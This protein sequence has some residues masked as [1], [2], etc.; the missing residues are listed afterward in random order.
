L[1]CRR[2]TLRRW[3]ALD[4][5]LSA[6]RD[7][8]RALGWE[9]GDGTELQAALAS[10]DG[11]AV[12]RRRPSLIEQADAARDARQWE[13]AA[14]CY[15]AVLDRDPGNAAIW[16][17]YGHALKEA[18]NLKDPARLAA[19]EAAYRSALTLKP[20]IADAYLQFGHVLKLQGRAEEAEAAYL[21]AFALDPVASAP[22]D[23]LRGLG[24]TAPA[25]T[26]LKNAALN[27]W[28]SS[29][30]AVNTDAPTSEI[31]DASILDAN[32]LTPPDKS[33]RIGFLK[34]L[35]E[36]FGIDAD[37]ITNELINRRRDEAVTWYRKFGRK[38]TIIIPS[39]RDSPV[40][41]NCIESIIATTSENMV[42]IVIVDDFSNQDDHLRFLRNIHLKYANV[43]L[44][45]GDANV[46]FSR[47]VN[48]GLHHCDEN[49]IVL[50]NSDV[51]MCSNS[52][53][54]ILQHAVFF[55]DA[56]IGSVRLIYPSEGIQ[57]GGGMRN[58]NEPIWFDHFFRKQAPS[59]VP[60]IPD[61]AYVRGSGASKCCVQNRNAEVRSFRL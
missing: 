13:L 35:D 38:V 41:N 27:C 52:W 25:L 37:I 5:A 8:L 20:G 22:I 56:G 9:E 30:K 1:G 53:L 48:R 7:E 51:E 47:N 18:G 36:S 42:E 46:G 29:D 6:A 15:R 60:A 55:N 10:L 11:F 54:E 16:V 32:G 3:L 50:I 4:A 59:F 45:F 58:F 2:R 43:R 19:A 33:A 23:E 61:K 57:F 21:R 39:F 28:P 14:R 17:Q 24:W 26:E 40:L 49:D 12:P 34:D 31:A 44:V